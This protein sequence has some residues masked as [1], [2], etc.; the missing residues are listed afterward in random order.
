MNSILHYES[1]KAA[2]YMWNHVLVMIQLTVHKQHICR[3]GLMELFQMN[4]KPALRV[5][6]TNTYHVSVY[7]PLPPVLKPVADCFKLKAVLVLSSCRHPIYYK[8]A[9]YIVHHI[10]SKPSQIQTAL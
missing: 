5:C 4:V 1:K 2:I 9:M 3:F 7:D 10:T 8:W 6:I